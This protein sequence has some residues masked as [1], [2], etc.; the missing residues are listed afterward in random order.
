MS[1]TNPITT[2]P[3]GESA[4]I[5][6]LAQAQYDAA[7]TI[8]GSTNPAEILDALVSFIGAS[9]RSALLGLIED[10]D[11]PLRLTV[12]AEY[13]DNRV[14]NTRHVIRLDDYPAYETFSAIEE[15]NFQD[16]ATDPFLNDAERERLTSQGIVSMLIIPMV[17]T[18]RL[19]GII[20][21][22]HS[23][24]VTISPARSRALRRLADQAAVVFENQS[25][26]RNTAASLEEVRSLYDINRAM[27]SALD[28]LDVL[29]VLRNLL[30][31]DVDTILHITARRSDDGAVDSSNY[32]LMHV[33][34]PESERLVETPLTLPPFPSNSNETTRV[35]FVESLTDAQSVNHPLYKEMDSRGVKSYAALLLRE[36]GDVNDIIVLAFKTPTVFDTRTRR[37]YTAV[38]DQTAIVL[39]NQRLLLEAQTN[40]IQL[41][42]QLRTLR[43]LNELSVNIATFDNE[44]ELLNYGVRTITTLLGVDHGGLMLRDQSRRFGVTVAEY[45]QTGTIGTTIGWND[46]PLA[47]EMQKNPRSPMVIEDIATDERIPL[48]LRM[49]LTQQV[50][51]QGM[52]ILPLF[53]KGDMVGSVGLDVYE[54]GYKFAPDLVQTAQTMAVQ[55]GI[56][57]ENVRLLNETRRSAAQ[58]QRIASFG[59]SVQAT[60][61]ADT[62]FKLMFTECS[63]MFP[64]NGITLTLWDTS[65]RQMREVG[66][67]MDGTINV[68]YPGGEVLQINGTF[69]GAVWESENPLLIPDIENAPKSL[70]LGSL[71]TETRALLSAPVFIRREPIGVVTATARTSYVFQQGDVAIFEQ[72]LNQFAVALENSRNYAQTQKLAENEALINEIGAQ[73]QQFNTIED[74]LQVTL[75]ELGKAIG[76]RRAR[77]RLATQPDEAAASEDVAR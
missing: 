64:L 25:L 46:N 76:A 73:I 31:P 37:L 58:I 72:L 55:L 22:S 24:V 60:L 32:L 18:Q 39:Q 8:Y 69:I 4:E 30:A 70:S 35:D 23:E 38:A 59:Q 41:S 53:V 7:G 27:L 63:Q 6:N 12:L 74:M 62:I 15:L 10:A 51:I 45:P 3:S 77:V 49:F 44:D 56:A 5:L 50:G 65:H 75:R 40:A 21:F 26:L 1:D 68:K 66:T 16:V 42:Q 28:T 71:P 13:H 20:V 54:R 2:S 14:T 17:V 48:E 57:L 47:I 43:L 11:A 9:Y 33:T 67:Y 29:R 19:I 61:Q 34:T 52:A 36:Q